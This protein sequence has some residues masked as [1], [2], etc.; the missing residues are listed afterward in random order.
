MHLASTTMSHPLRED[1]DGVVRIGATRVTLQTVVAAYDQGST[2]EEITL[3][4]PVLSLE[5]V[6]ST[7]SFFLANEGEL[8]RYVAEEWAAGEEARR[9]SERQPAVARLRERLRA[10]RPG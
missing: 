10:R 7:I 9:E 3:R 6:Y 5:Q 2:P 1:A 4:Y 8:R